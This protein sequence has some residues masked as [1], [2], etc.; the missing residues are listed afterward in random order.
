[1]PLLELGSLPADGG[2]L[3]LDAVDM[4]EALNDPVARRF[5]RQYVGALELLHGK[6]RWCFWLADVDPAEWRES[7]LVRERVELVR[8]FRSASV[9]IPTQR[10]A[11]W[12]HQF[13]EIRQP[14]VDYLA[15]PR[16]VSEARRWL[17]TARLKPDVITSEANFAAADP[18]GTTF[19][20][21]SSGIFLAWALAVSG[22]FRSTLR[23][24][25]TFVYN[26]FPLP[27][28]SDSQRH[29]MLDAAQGVLSARTDASLADQYDVTTMPRQLV[30][31]HV[32][33]DRVM[34]RI[35]E[36]SKPTLAAR[37]KRLFELADQDR[38]R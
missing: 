32:R 29:V 14:V 28:L 37:Q 21:L 18:D 24:S 16:N 13:T 34:D 12:P 1:M 31:A 11:M 25:N 9:K 36:V 2:H 26:N 27:D 17:P 19:A 4:P 33:L 7:R 15:V 6:K 20:V 23:L 35:F 30:D 5:V 10:A 22:R 38:R 3:I 8:R